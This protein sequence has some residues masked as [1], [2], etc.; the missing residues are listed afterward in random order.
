MTSEKEFV[1]QLTQRFPAVPPVIVGIGDDG[2]V[3]DCGDAD[4]QVVVTDMLLDGVHFDLTQISPMLAGR[5]AVAVN[6]SDLAAMACRPTAAFI[7]LAL[8]KSLSTPDDFLKQLYDG[9]EDLADRYR[10]SV[11]GGDTN[12]WDGPFAINVCLTGVP[13]QSR[14]VLRS[15][16]QPGDAL[17]VTGPLGGSLRN[18]RHLTFEPRLHLAQWLAEHAELHAM[19]DISDGLAID[20]YRLMEASGTGAVVD[21][22]RIPIHPDVSAELPEHDRLHRALSDGED[23]EL[24]VALSPTDAERLR[25]RTA[26][27]G[28]C[29]IGTVTESRAIMLTDFSGTARPLAGI[30][31]QHH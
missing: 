2:A 12:S 13:M 6:L 17:I 18:G 26:G 11:A 5:K 31:W 19:I 3:M 20:L 1:R 23:F 29:G 15:G 14:P 24:L 27:S 25:Q 22:N 9:I 21:S 30:G 4:Q 16:A 8:P 7:S 10:F 28:I